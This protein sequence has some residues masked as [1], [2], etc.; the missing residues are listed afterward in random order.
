M[1]MTAMAVVTVCV[2]ALASSAAFGG[3]TQFEFSLDQ[4][5]VTSA[6]VYTP[7]GLMVR[8]LWSLKKFPAGKTAEQ[9]D[10]L[11][12]FGRNVP[13]GAYEVRV[14]CSKAAYFSVGTIGNSGVGKPMQSGTDDLITDRATGDIYTANNWEEAG[15]DFRKTDANG[16]HMTDAR[17]GVRNGK[18]NGWP[19]AVALEGDVLYCS[20]FAS[21][22]IVPGLTK[23][24]AGGAVIRKFNALDGNALAF[25][26]ET[27]YIRVKMPDP[28][29]PKPF[30][31]Q[32]LHSITICGNVIV[33]ADRQTG[34]VY[35]FD[36]TTG[37]PL[38]QFTV[39]DP[40]CAIADGP[41]GLW[42]AYD[43]NQLIA[44]DLDG[45][46]LARPQ[47]PP[48]QIACIRLA[49]PNQLWVADQAAGQI[50]VYTIEPNK[51]LTPLKAYGHKAKPG[52]FEPLA[53]G[54]IQSFD[55]EPDGGF[56]LAQTYG[57]GTVVTRFTADGNVVWQQVG[58]EFC[59]NGT[60]DPKQPDLFISSMTNAYRLLD[61]A[62]GTWRF[63][64]CL[65]QGP[66]RTGQ[67]TGTPRIVTLGQHRYYYALSGDGVRVFRFEG[68]RLVPSALVGMTQRGWDPAVLGELPDKEKPTH[69]TWHDASGDGA[70]QPDEIV[71]LVDA[72]KQFATYSCEVD[73]QGNLIIPNRRNNVIYE[74]PLARMDDHANPVY[75]WADLRPVLPPD[76]T[77]RSLQPM[78]ACPLPDGGM[79]V[80]QVAEPGFYPPSD[81]DTGYG[82]PAGVCWMG[83]WVF[84][85]YDRQGVRLF[86]VPLPE[87][88]TAIDWVP[89]PD[90]NTDGGIIA[91]AY[92]GKELYHYSPD[93]LLLG[94]LSP[95]FMTGWL[96]HNGAVSICR[97]PT[98]GLADVF[99]EESFQNRISW[100]R[101]DDRQANT[102][103]LPVTKSP[104]AGETYAAEKDFYGL[105]R[106]GLAKA[107]ER[108]LDEANCLLTAAFDVATERE[109]TFVH[110]AL[111]G[112]LLAIPEKV[113][114]GLAHLQQVAESPTFDGHKRAD[115]IFQ[116][117]VA[118]RK[119]KDYPRALAVLDLVAKLPVAKQR[120]YIPR[121]MLE[122]ARTHLDANDPDAARQMAQKV[123]DYYKA[124]TKEINPNYHR[125]AFN[126]LAAAFAREGKFEEAA[127][128]YRQGQQVAGL[129]D[130]GR[131]ASESLLGQMY[132]GAKQPAKAAECFDG[133]ARKF[134]AVSA[135]TRTDAAFRAADA[136]LLAT[137]LAG[138]RRSCQSV[139]DDPAAAAENVQ[140]AKTKLAVIDKQ[141][142]RPAK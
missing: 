2:A 88:C 69:Y 78:K 97:N 49:T 89:G 130:E 46:V 68:T 6:A 27:G 3:P 64:G 57:H 115:V 131:A 34:I 134:P 37:G 114:E 108:K 28:N 132:S 120:D 127:A 141:T 53:I 94:V 22:D 42:I 102:L 107:K 60:Y 129:D 81:K 29:D 82:K 139:I 74:L 13:P 79:Y 20:V 96:D 25:P 40:I 111:G 38:G 73:R 61:D 39:K 93:G 92:H 138:A 128:E 106:D 87:H 24:V 77:L 15:Q 100:Y 83:G 1:R 43:G 19:I 104:A 86:T 51:K 52:E 135:S 140:K 5:C 32:S 14:G 9:W 137:D 121:A 33:A 110:Q 122:M 30:N 71:R 47:Y 55:I 117:N 112:M 75:D 62:N 65:Y 118:C 41:G 103:R 44:T 23:K 66:I 98:D 35:K 90:G 59:T 17:F 4:E 125:E 126:V 36:K 95:K 58:L 99:V 119:M 72:N 101:M 116:I 142:S 26:T 124:N 8:T 18:P 123:K 113:A 31:H 84:S 56:V 21:G 136:Y 133:I 109:K 12:D 7:D 48:A 63:E 50:Q 76:A 85:K 105:Y 10:G 11:D 67:S 80:L 70:V 45:K 91:G 16:V 54:K